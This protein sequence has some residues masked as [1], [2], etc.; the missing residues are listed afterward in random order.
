M[1]K[2]FLI[3]WTVTVFATQ[4][5]SQST[6]GPNIQIKPD[7]LF[8]EFPSNVDSLWVTNHGNSDLQIDSLTTHETFFW[9]ISVILKDTTFYWEVIN[10]KPKPKQSLNLAPKDTALLIFQA[11]DVCPVCKFTGVAPFTDTLFVFS[12]DSL[13]SPVRIFASGEGFSILDFV[14]DINSSNQDNFELFQNYPNPFNPETVIKYK[15]PQSSQVELTVYN[16]IGQKI[17]TLINETQTAGIHQ[18]RWD[19]TDDLGKRVPSGVYIYHVKTG[20][21]TNLRKMLLLR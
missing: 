18:V 2:L 12:N 16:L 1:R 10:Q 20:S 15:V 11:P 13:R 14:E 17:R 6:N 8:F 9:N 4:S 3:L 7:T 21:F 5:F 19:G